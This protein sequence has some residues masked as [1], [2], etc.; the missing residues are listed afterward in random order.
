MHGTRGIESLIPIP[1]LQYEMV[2]MSVIMYQ[3]LLQKKLI[4]HA[5]QLSNWIPD[6]LVK[7]KKVKLCDG[8]SWQ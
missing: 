3:I 1:V 2:V 7:G 5:S 4:Q 8:Y 6:V